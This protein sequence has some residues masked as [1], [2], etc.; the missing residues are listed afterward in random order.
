MARS[1]NP[2]WIL[3]SFSINFCFC[4]L[5]WI[6]HSIPVINQFQPL[7]T[8]REPTKDTRTVGTWIHLN[9]WTIQWGDKYSPVLCSGAIYIN[10]HLN[11]WHFVR[12]AHRDHSYRL[13]NSFW[14]SN[15]GLV[16]Y[17]VT[18]C[19][20]KPTKTCKFYKKSFFKLLIAVR[21]FLFFIFCFAFLKKFTI[22]YMK[23][24]LTSFVL[25]PQYTST[26]NK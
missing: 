9:K 14:Y 26:V 24:V 16:H 17:S 10:G 3:F 19:L 15:K 7:K 12:Y 21:Y 25:I 6:G 13:L 8:S 18:H 20:P 1:L 11:N 22:F 23:L 2:F 5:F 4:R